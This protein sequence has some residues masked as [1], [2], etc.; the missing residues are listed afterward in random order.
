MVYASALGYRAL[1]ARMLKT[2]AKC[3]VWWGGCSSSGPRV[4]GALSS[5][6]RGEKCCVKV[7]DCTD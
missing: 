3:V 1:L 4:D 7:K 2:K 6:R 5:R